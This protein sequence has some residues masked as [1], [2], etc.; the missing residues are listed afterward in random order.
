MRS[1]TPS[2]T[3]HRSRRTTHAGAPWYDAHAYSVCGCAAVMAWAIAASV[4]SVVDEAD[5]SAAG[6]ITPRHQGGDPQ[7][8]QSGDTPFADRISAQG[9]EKGNAL[10]GQAC[11]LHRHDG[12][13]SCG[14]LQV[15]QGP[16]D[17]ARLRQRIHLQEGDPFLMADNG[18]LQMGEVVQ[19]MGSNDFAASRI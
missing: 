1:R 13:G 3:N 18:K 9:S 8:F 14:F 16:T 2:G 15:T 5:P 17:P 6:S 11:E 10:A 4:A 7:G 19:G 12:S